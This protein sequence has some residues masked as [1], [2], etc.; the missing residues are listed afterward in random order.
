MARCFIKHRGLLPLNSAYDF[1]N[2]WWMKRKFW[3]PCVIF[4]RVPQNAVGHQSCVPSSVQLHVL[5]PSFSR[6]AFCIVFLFSS[7]W[8]APVF[9][10]VCMCPAQQ[11]RRMCRL[12]VKARGKTFHMSVACT[13]Q[14]WSWRSLSSAALYSGGG[15]LG[16][17]VGITVCEEMIFKHKRFYQSLL[18]TNWCTIDLL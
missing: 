13:C 9:T 17:S 6:Y 5:F 10:A 18:F 4:V 16:V 12:R 1:G 15:T 3:G 2:G 7:E 14:I 8:R 11:A